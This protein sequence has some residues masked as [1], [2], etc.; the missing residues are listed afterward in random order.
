MCSGLSQV[1]DASLNEEFQLSRSVTFRFLMIEGSMK[2]LS[3]RKNL[4]CL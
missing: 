3:N 4:K 2:K 1:S